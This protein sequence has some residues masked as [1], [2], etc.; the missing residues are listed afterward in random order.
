MKKAI[1]TGATGMIG[2]ALIKLLL[3]ENYDII[4][5]VRPNSKKINNIPKDGKIDIGRSYKKTADNK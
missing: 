2:V 5:I 3:K 1:V 4:A